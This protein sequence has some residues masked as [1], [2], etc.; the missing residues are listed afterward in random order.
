MVSKSD[1]RYRRSLI[2]LGLENPTSI[3]V[4][5]QLGRTLWADSGSQAKIEIAW[6]DGSKRKQLVIDKIIEPTALTIDYGMDHTVYWSDAKLNTIE[7]IR[8]DGSNRKIILKGDNLESPASLDVFENHLYWMTAVTGNLVKQDKFGRGVPE[9]IA[10]DIP[11]PGGVKVYHRLR[12]NTTLRDPCYSD[13]C[14]HLCVAVPGG[15]RCLCPD[16]VGPRQPQSSERQCDAT[17]E[18]PRP[19]PRICLCENGG[20]CHELDN[21]LECVCPLN[22]HG[23]YCELG[24]VAARAGD[25]T[26]AIIIPIL[27]T[28]LILLGAAAII[29]VLKKRPL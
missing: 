13:Q 28:I 26:T 19:A 2:T 29:M 20:V 16:S 8:Q 3:V 18:R 27:V 11:H 17:S 6:M 12:Y 4:D 5:P 22:Y 7:S 24:L 10:R 1:G 25:S 15:H 14:T 9:I 21:G 23:Q